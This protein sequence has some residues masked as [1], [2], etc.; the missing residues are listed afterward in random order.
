MVGAAQMVKDWTA[1]LLKK[2]PLPTDIPRHACEMF[3]ANAWGAVIDG[4]PDGLPNFPEKL[5]AAGNFSKVPLV[6]GTNINEGAMF[7]WTFPL[8]WGSLPY[9]IPRAENMT[10]IAEWFLRNTSDQ[11][12]FLQ[13]YAG[14]NWHWHGGPAWNIDR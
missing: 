4:A 13:L 10:K 2:E 11:K 5:L 8:L 1:R 9:P 6:V 3:P 12:R 14:D 7:G